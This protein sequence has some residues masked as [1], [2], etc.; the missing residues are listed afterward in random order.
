VWD[1]AEIHEE[2]SSAPTPAHLRYRGAVLRANHAVRLGLRAASRN[3]EL[4]FAKAL[5][6]QAGTL[7]AILP[8][9]LAALLIAG[10]ARGAV[11]PAVARAL[12]ALVVLGWPVLGGVLTAL[13]IAFTAGMLFWSGAVPLL[14]AD[15]ELNR[16][17][18]PGNFIVLVSRGAA[19]TLLAGI[20]GWGLSL[21]FSL[22]CAAAIV[23]AVP[24]AVL[25]PSPRLFAGAAL[26]GAAALLGGLLLDLLARLTLV[27][28][29]AFG[30]SASAAFGKAASLLGARLGACL[31]VTLAF[32][33]LELIVASSAAVFTGVLSGGAWLDP[34]AELLALAPRAAVGLAAAAVFAWL[35]VGRM[36][37]L[38]ALAADAEGLIEPPAPPEPPPVAELVVEA[39][40]ADEV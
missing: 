23:V 40:P 22:S 25:R 16:R 14:A 33:L 12:R 9:A 27:R 2:V 13:A 20:L 8:L 24:A 35:E 37:A 34:A 18:P 39:L 19:R 1:S 5:V 15:A 17:P 32:V 28:A 31:A 30:D 21:L 29:A 7:L 36:G 11:L 10:A 4:S 38:A 3:P 26:V 6:D